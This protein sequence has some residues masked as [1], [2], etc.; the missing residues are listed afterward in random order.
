MRFQTHKPKIKSDCSNFLMEN[1]S[2]NCVERVPMHIEKSYIVFVANHDGWKETLV[3]IIWRLG[4]EFFARDH[5]RFLEHDKQKHGKVTIP[6]LL[7]CRTNIRNCKCQ[8]WA[9]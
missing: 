6:Y 1:K 2:R 5:A 8:V 7:F 3:Q 9:P 4:F